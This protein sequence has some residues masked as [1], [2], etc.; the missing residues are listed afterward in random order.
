MYYLLI[1]SNAGS[2]FFLVNNTFLSWENPTIS[3]NFGFL[4]T[5]FH[6]GPPKHVLLNK[7]PMIHIHSTIQA[8]Y[9]SYHLSNVHLYLRMRRL[10]LVKLIHVEEFMFCNFSESP[11]EV[12]CLFHKKIIQT[13]KYICIHYSL[14][15][16]YHTAF[17]MKKQK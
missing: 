3:A 11:S 17:R 10:C 5:S 4:S 1:N 9:H 7:C 8:F 14:K 15:A 16:R 6:S 13:H 12:I 2:F